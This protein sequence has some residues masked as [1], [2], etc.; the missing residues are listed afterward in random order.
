MSIWTGTPE[1]PKPF[2]V[3][4]VVLVD[5][6]GRMLRYPVEPARRLE[7]HE[8]ARGR[9]LVEVIRDRNIGPAATP[10]P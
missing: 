5:D 9:F 4:A 3:A 2:R 6:D 8:I 1:K 7:D 10:A